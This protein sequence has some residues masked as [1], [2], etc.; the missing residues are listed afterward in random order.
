MSILMMGEG[1]THEK[2][3]SAL[4]A[5]ADGSEEL[6]AVATIDVMRR[7]DVRVTVA[8]VCS[9]EKGKT[10]VCSRGVKIEADVRIEDLPEDQ[11]FDLIAIPGGMPGAKNLY[12]NL[13]LQQLLKQQ[14]SA[15]RFVAAICAAP[16]V[17]LGQLGLLEKKNATC[18]H[19][20]MEKLAG[21]AGSVSEA[22]V[23]VDGNFITSRGP[24]TA[25]EFGLECVEVLCGKEI[26]QKVQ[27]PMITH[28]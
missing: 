10:V 6:E 22:R 24:G 18:H 15:G 11:E 26:R 9:A 14:A 2:K 17:V 7:G 25:I 4:V 28:L 27:N 5:V 23:V 3:K 16:A 8:A 12:E 20:F 13:K 21:Q 1:E 19:G